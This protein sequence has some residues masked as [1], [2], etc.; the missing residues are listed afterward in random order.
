MLKFVRLG[1]HHFPTGIPVQSPSTSATSSSVTMLLV[2]LPPTPARRRLRRIE[3]SFEIG[4]RHVLKFTEPS[5]VLFRA[6]RFELFF[7][8][9]VLVLQVIPPLAPL[10]PRLQLRLHLG[11]RGLKLRNLG[12]DAAAGF[13]AHGILV[14]RE[15]VPLRRQRLKAPNFALI[16]V[17]GDSVDLNTFP[18][19]RFVQ[20]IHCTLWQSAI[21]QRTLR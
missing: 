21:L 8:T 13:R 17:R 4:Q 6:R 5:K 9:R 20:E 15:G 18:R 19:C 3:P 2:M 7:E 14:I 12:I 1:L 16:D 10:F 11:D